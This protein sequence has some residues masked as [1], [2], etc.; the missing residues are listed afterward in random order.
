MKEPLITQDGH[1]HIQI[2]V[3]DLSFSERLVEQQVF[4]YL[5]DVTIP[6]I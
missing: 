1:E 5:S 3:I 4:V 6:N 2:E